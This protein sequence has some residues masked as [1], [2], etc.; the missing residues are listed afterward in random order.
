M[1]HIC[2]RE[3]HTYENPSLVSMSENLAEAYAA[4][5]KISELILAVNSYTSLMHYCWLINHAQY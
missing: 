5:I 3:T 1:L 2:G 4:T